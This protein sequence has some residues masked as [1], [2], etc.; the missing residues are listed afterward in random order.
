MRGSHALA[1][2]SGVRVVDPLDAD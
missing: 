1:T 2:E